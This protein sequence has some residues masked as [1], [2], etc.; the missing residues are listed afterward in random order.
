MNLA[1][2][3]EEVRSQLVFI[4]ITVGSKDCKI[5]ITKEDEMTTT[6][7]NITGEYSANK[8]TVFTLFP[9]DHVVNLP[10][11]VILRGP[12]G[13]SLTADNFEAKQEKEK[14]NYYLLTVGAVLH[15]PANTL[16]GEYKGTYEV[17]I[18]I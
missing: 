5:A 13:N 7:V 14:F 12:N 9:I 1:P 16:G 8:F 2:Y 11:S 4:K 18:I 3:A 6:C 15:I 10:K 17:K